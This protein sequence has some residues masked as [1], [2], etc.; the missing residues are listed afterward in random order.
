MDRNRISLLVSIW[1]SNMGE[2][3]YFI[4]L[5]LI[6][7]NMTNSPITVSVLYVLPYIASI[8]TNT[9]AGSWVDRLNQKKLLVVLDI[10]RGIL[11]LLLASTSSL[12]LIY[13]VSLIIHMASSI[14]STTSFVYMTKLV[15]ESEQQRFNAWKNFVQSSGFFVGPS[16]A[17][18][19]FIIGTPN[20]AILFNGVML[21]LSASVLTSLKNLD[22]K[23]KVVH[24]PFSFKMIIEDWVYIFRFSKQNRFVAFLYLLSSSVIV[25]MAALDS[26][27][28]AFSTTILGFSEA[29][30]GLLVSIAGLGVIL[31]SLANARWGN[32]YN[33][34]SLVKYGAFFTAIGYVIYALS[35]SFIMAALGFFLLTFAYTFANVGFLTFIQH[36]IPTEILGRFTSIFKIF[37]SVVG[38]LAIAIVGIITEV[39]G[40]RHIVLTVSIIFFVLGVINFIKISST[41]TQEK[42]AVQENL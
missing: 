5:N 12:L 23:Q 33:P 19:L 28:A 27:E 25:C 10:V 7:L 24:E 40:L 3:V 42:I 15:P 18:M 6:V 1:V 9:W 22:S 8:L 17:G 35:S 16:I 11:V 2:W 30:Y 26:I 13:V 21:F 39:V 32:R 31:G 36:R 20:M 29:E 37:E 38:I 34:L 41:I 4:A 14:F